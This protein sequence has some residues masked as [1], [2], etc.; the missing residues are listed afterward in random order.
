METKLSKGGKRLGAGR[1]PVTERKQ[2][3]SLYIQ[4]KKFIKFGSEAKMKE[5]LYE[6]IDNF[7]EGVL[8]VGQPKVYD[9]LL[10][11]KNYFSDEPKQPAE[12][13]KKE[14]SNFESWKKEISGCD[15]SYELEKLVSLMEKDKDLLW[16]EKN[17]L[18]R[19][20]LQIGK[21]KGFQ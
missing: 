5:K 8:P 1:K 3:V 13:N 6:Y 9:D 16:N 18:K 20:C 7:G 19:F 15:E 11:N 2:Q 21:Q 12:P 10:V 17:E 14:L 4:P